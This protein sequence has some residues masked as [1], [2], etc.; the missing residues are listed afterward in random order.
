MSDFSANHVKLEKKAPLF[1]E[2]RTSKNKD[3]VK[4]SRKTI[5]IERRTNRQYLRNL[6][7]A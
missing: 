5:R 1:L 3:G 2:V 4:R 6:P 7:R